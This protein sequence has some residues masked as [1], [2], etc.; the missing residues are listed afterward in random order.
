[1]N[2][3]FIE[4]DIYKPPSYPL[5]YFNELLGEIVCKLETEKKYVYITGDFNSNTL[6]SNTS[7]EEFKNILSCNHITK[8][9]ASISW[10]IF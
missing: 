8:S 9:S 4:I 7:T 3:L 10:K 5:H 1:M 6:I 2:S